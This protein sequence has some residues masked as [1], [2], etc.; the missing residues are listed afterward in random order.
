MHSSSVLNDDWVGHPLFTP[1][2]GHFVPTRKSIY[3]EALFKCEEER[4]EF[5]LAIEANLHAIHLLEPI[6]KKLAA[7][8]AIDRQNFKLEPGLGGSSKTIYQRA[9]KRIYDKERGSEIIDALHHSPG[10]AVPVVLK[11]LK[12]KDEEWKRCQ[13][14]LFNIA[15]VEQGLG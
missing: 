2:N 7:M 12:Q 1:E 15:R 11:R 10:V 13:V 6:S 8:S 9:I 5:D 14:T 4:Y 3:E